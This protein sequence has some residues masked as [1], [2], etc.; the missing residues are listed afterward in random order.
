LVSPFTVIGLAGPEAVCPAFDLTVYDVMRLPPFEA[1]ASKL[2]FAPALSAF[3]F[4]ITGA[5]GTVMAG[6]TLLDAAE[7]GP[8]PILFAAVTVNV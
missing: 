1:G 3:A 8:V 6:V 4:T 7:G 5:S 2:T